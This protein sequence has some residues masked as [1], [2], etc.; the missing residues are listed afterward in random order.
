MNEIK[1]N[2]ININKLIEIISTKN[3]T[4]DK[5]KSQID[6]Y[7]MQIK[8]LN[9]K[10]SS[11]DHLI[12]DYNSLHN[13]YIKMENELLLSVKEINN[14]KLIINSKNKTIKEYQ[15]LFLDTKSRF[16]LYDN[17][18]ELLQKKINYL[19]GQLKYTNKININEVN[20]KIDEYNL[21]IQ[22]IKDEFN[23]NVNKLKNLKN[24][25][26]CNNIDFNIKEEFLNN[27][28]SHD[29]NIFN[30]YKL[31]NNNLVEENNYL[32]EILIK[33]EK[34]AKK[35]IGEIKKEFNLKENE[36]KQKDKIIKDIIKEKEE[37]L[38]KINNKEINNF[39]FENNYKQKY[40]VLK[41]LVNDIEKEKKLIQ[42]NE[43]KNI[44]IYKNEISRLKNEINKCFID[45]RKNI[46]KCEEIKNKYKNLLENIQ[47][48]EDKYKQEIFNLN[49]LIDKLKKDNENI[50]TN[51][52]VIKQNEELKEKNNNLSG[53]IL[54]LRNYIN[55]IEKDKNICSSS[56]NNNKCSYN[57]CNDELILYDVCCDCHCIHELDIIN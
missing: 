56:Q 1:E 15:Q 47:I 50:K 28:D 31:K 19:E 13:D 27:E 42:S 16:I 20:H 37:L 45:D 17:L 35:I 53:V 52:D 49:N 38:K 24:I 43:D 44:N 40:E 36:I 34:E 32:K 18:N 4:I 54:G 51:K 26:G 7:E 46:E 12:I 22:Q 41:N 6:I 30:K 39:L 21:K 9:E 3:S 33:K 23:K 29:D 55:N 14:L 2:S 8:E 25:S 57:C 48:K 11:C 5:L 10:I